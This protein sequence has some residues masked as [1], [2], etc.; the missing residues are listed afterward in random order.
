LK[1]PKSKFLWK[2]KSYNILDN[3]RK[4]LLVFS[5]NEISVNCSAINGKLSSEW[6]L[7]FGIQNE[8]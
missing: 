2:T 6:F 8:V 1:I 4:L 7:Y 3:T 5:Y